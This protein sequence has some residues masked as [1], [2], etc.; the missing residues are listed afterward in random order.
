MTQTDDA[1]LMKIL[2]DPVRGPP[3]EVFTN[4]EIS[5]L[6]SMSFMIWVWVLSD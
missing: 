1:E 5:F 6:M 4:I 3:R 2:D